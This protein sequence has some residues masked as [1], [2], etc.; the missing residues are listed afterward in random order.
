M[1]CSAAPGLLERVSK[2][3]ALR[4]KL[5]ELTLLGEYLEILT[6]VIQRV[7]QRFELIHQRV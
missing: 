5:L 1:R 4:A 2:V 6:H 7:E 3:G